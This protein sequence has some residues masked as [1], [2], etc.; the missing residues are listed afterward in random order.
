M[1]LNLRRYLHEVAAALIE[2]GRRM[3]AFPPLRPT[4]QF[5][6]NRYLSSIGKTDLPPCRYSAGRHFWCGISA[7]TDARIS[8]S[9]SM[10]AIIFCS[11]DISIIQRSVWPRGVARIEVG[12]DRLL[13]ARGLAP[14]HALNR[15]DFMPVSWYYL[16]KFCPRTPAPQETIDYRPG[17]CRQ[18]G[19][20]YGPFCC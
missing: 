12:A 20:D 6:T 9:S 5:E 14:Q 3:S 19:Q 4:I 16:P 15:R 11:L 13:G 1:D 17:L 10:T 2:R 8:G 7:P 18:E